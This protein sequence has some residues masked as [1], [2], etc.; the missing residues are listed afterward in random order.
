MPQ[1]RVTGQCII[2]G[3]QHAAREAEDYLDPL[4]DKA[5][6]QNLSAGL[7]H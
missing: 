4:L 5:F 2:E 6:T 3:Q 7:Y 1:L